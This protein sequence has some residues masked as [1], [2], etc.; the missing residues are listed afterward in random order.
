MKP[1]K[2]IIAGSRDFDDY[3]LLKKETVD[4]LVKSVGTMKD[5]TDVEIVSGGAKGAD[6]LGERFAA[7]HQLKVTLF[8]ADWKNN[9]R[10]AGPIRNKQMA[11]YGTHLLAFWNGQSKGTGSMVKLA[12]KNNLNVHIVSL[13]PQL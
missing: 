3:E 8:P 1:I 4:F 9:G 7:E 13:T 10:A 6:A 11:E 12:N 5:L 2:L